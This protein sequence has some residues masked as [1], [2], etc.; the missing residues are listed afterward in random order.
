MNFDRYNLLISSWVLGVGF[1]AFS[2]P[3]LIVP[4]RWLKTGGIRMR[5]PEGSLSPWGARILFGLPFTAA[6]IFVLRYAINATSLALAGKLVLVKT[7]AH[8]QQPSLVSPG[9]DSWQRWLLQISIIIGWPIAALVWTNG[10]FAL[11]SPHQWEASSWTAKQGMQGRS[12]T[13]QRAFGAIMCLG[14]ILAVFALWRLTGDAWQ[15]R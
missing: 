12:A 10:L 2:L 11:I 13:V 3:A 9:T 15:W 1:L 8:V 5:I 14:G 7:G 6:G 4:E